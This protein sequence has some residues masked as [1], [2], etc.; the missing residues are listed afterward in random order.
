MLRGVEDSS[1]TAEQTS[2]LPVHRFGLLDVPGLTHGITSR[3]SDLPLNGN[4][5]FMV[6]DAPDLVQTNR[7]AWASAIGYDP[8]LLVLGRQ[9]H[10]TT[11]FAVDESHAGS[12]AQSVETSIR[13]VDGLMTNVPG[14]PLG[15]MAADCVP[16][17]IHDPGLGA[18]AAVHAGWR[19]TVDGIASI[20]VARM[21][22]AYGTEP[23]G[24]K[25]GLGP[26][27]CASCYQVGSEVVDRWQHGP[28][29]T[30]ADPVRVTSD[31]LYFDLREANRGQLIAAGV[32]PDRIEI[33]DV[34]TQCSNG[35]QFSRRG[36][37]PRTGLFTSIIM[38]DDSSRIDQGRQS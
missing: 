19:G 16:L 26:S 38:L 4:M 10:E 25:I 33:S 35:A 37:G 27:I 14:I 9:V 1:N 36:L 28:V 34:C 6:G 29:S 21:A 32:H 30:T 18:V 7:V 23:A 2:T 20:A 5:S 12:G 22:D 3:T 17:L 15:V 11:V 8:N 24:L 31:G 13:R